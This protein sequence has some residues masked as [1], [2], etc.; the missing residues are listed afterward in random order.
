[1]LSEAADDCVIGAAKEWIDGPYLHFVAVLP[2]YEG[3]GKMPASKGLSEQEQK[4]GFEFRAILG[5]VTARLYL[6]HKA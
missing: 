3:S 1:M 6:L 2:I 4:D 5:E